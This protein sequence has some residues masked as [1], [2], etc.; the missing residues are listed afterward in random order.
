MTSPKS[1]WPGAS[2]LAERWKKSGIAKAREAYWQ[3][4]PLAIGGPIQTLKARRGIAQASHG[5]FVTTK[6]RGGYPFQGLSCCLQPSSPGTEPTLMDDG[7]TTIWMVCLEHSFLLTLNGR[8][9]PASK[10]EDC[11][12]H[13]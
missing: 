13:R 6:R 9:P 7:F 1:A 11:H 5:A 12:L 3:P 2:K 4:R 8:M 10:A